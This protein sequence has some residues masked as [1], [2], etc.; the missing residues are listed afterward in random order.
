MKKTI[1]ALLAA[2][3]LIQACGNN[4]STTADDKSADSAAAPAF[5]MPPG[6]KVGD[7]ATDFFLKNIDGEMVSLKDFEGAKGH[8]VIFTCNHCPY[9]QKYEDRIIALDEKFKPLG[10]PVVAINPNDT[11][12][13]PEDSYTEMQKV[14]AKKEYPFPYL[15]DEKQEVYPVYGA[16]KTPHVY[17]LKNENGKHIVKYIGAID[18]NY[19]DTT[20]ITK[21]YVEDAIAALEAGTPIAETNT[22]AVGCTI[23]DKRTEKKK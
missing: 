22:A 17:I 1:Y 14:A 5:V 4:T 18:D 3:L 10:Y 11:I 21:R 2:S 12:M 9:A 19:E 7:E 20:K 6:Y 23:K 15:I 13:Q 16:T 8:I